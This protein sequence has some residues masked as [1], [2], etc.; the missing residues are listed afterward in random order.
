MFIFLSKKIAIPNNVKLRCASWNSEQGWIACGGQHGLLKVLRLESAAQTDGK[1]PRGI[2]AASNLTMNQSL[3]GH[4][5][6][7]V[8][9]T[10]NANFKKLTTSDEN[11]LIIVWVLHRGMW[12]E[13]MI[14][15]RNKS[16][17]RDM[18]WTTDG[19]KI[20][21][22]YEDGAVI[23][24][25]V[26]GNRLWGKEMKTQLAFVEWAPDGK[27]LLFVTKEGEV[28]VHDAMG[29]K[30]SNLTLY[31]VESRGGG[32][33]YKIIGVHWY[34]G[35]EGHISQEAPTLAIAFRDGKVQITRGR[36]DE[37]AV[38]I[39]TGME[40]TQ[41]R[42][43]NDGSVIA[44]A[45][46][47]VDNSASKGD[48]P[49]E[50]NVVQFYDPFGRH[51]RSLRVPG[52]RIEAL[53]WE[54]TGLRICLA[55]DSHIYF[56]NIRPAYKWGYYANTLVYTYNRA[57]QIENCVVF[58]DTKSD[59]R[60]TKY[61]RGLLAIKAAGDNCV[62]VTKIYNE[63]LGTG[64][65]NG[66]LIDDE[67][68]VFKE[69]QYQLILCDTIGSPIES[70]IIDFEP[71]FVAMTSRHIVAAS[72]DA[73][74][75]WQ[76][77][78]SSAKLTGLV[79]GHGSQSHDA[80]DVSTIS[81]LLQR[82]G[83]REKAF[84]ID[85]TQG[86]DV[87]HFR[88]VARQLEDPI[89]AICAS[90]SWIFA[91][92]ASGL[93][94]C[95][96]LPHI[97]LEM[98]YIVNCRPQFL[99]LNCNSTMLSVIDINGLLTIME[100]GAAGSLNTTQGKMLSFEKKDAW[101]V[102]WAEDNP[103]LFVM[104]EKARMYVYRS[105]E[106][107]EPVSSSGYLCYYK[108][109]QVKAA[110]LDEILANPEQ[111]DK[112]MVIEF[113]T[114]SLRDA[115]AL[116]D[117]VGLAEACEYIQDHP[118]PRLWS[119]LAEAALDQLDFGMAE[120]GFV[121]CG[122]YSGIQYVK[123]LQV[124]N[125]RVKQKAEVAAYF[126]NFD[127]AEA[128]Y[129]KIDRKDL[130]I[131]LRQ[132]LGD[133]FRVVQLVQ[134]GGGNDDLLTHAWNMIGEYFS[135]RHKWEK[136]IKYYAQ[137]KNTNALV[138]CYYALG[139]FNQL[140]ALVND[141]PESS[142]L[143][144]D[145]AVKFTRAGLCQSA[146]ET[147]VRMGD[148]KSAIDSCVLL[149]EWERAVGLAEQYNF[150]QIE[151]VLT[152]YASHLMMNGKTLQAIELYRRANKSTEAAKLLAKL[153][154][155]VA[156]NPLRAKKLH[157]LA[158][159][160]VERMRKKML[161]VSNLTS[162]KG[163]TAAQVTAQTLE[164]LVQHDAATGEDRSLD[165][166]W[167]GAEAYHL[168]LLAHRQLYG[169]RIERALRTCLKL[170]AYED[171]LE[172]REIYSLIALT[173]F[174]TK[175]YEQCSKAFVKLE[176]LPGLD[177]K[178]LQ[179][180]SELA[181]KIFTTTRTEH[182]DPTMRPQECPNCR[183]QVKEWDARCGNC[184]RP[185]PTCMMTGMSIQAQ[186]TKMCK[187]CRHVCIETEIRDQKNCP[188]CHTAFSF[189]PAATNKKAESAASGK[190]SDK[191]KDETEVEDDADEEEEAE[192]E[193]DEESD[194]EVEEDTGLTENQN[195]LL[196][197]VSLYSK[198]AVRA[199]DK[200][201]WIRKPAL[202]V[203]LYEAIV[204]KALDYD[205]APSSELVEN[206]RKY[207]NISQEGK[208]DL[209]FLR[210]EDLVNGLK[211]SSKTY[212]PVTCFQISEKGLEIIAK[213]SKT[214][215][216]AVN[217]MAYAPGTLHLLRVEWDGEEYWLV[218]DDSGYRRLSSVTETE[219][220]SYVSS[221]YIPQCL[222]FGGR[223]T[224]SNAHRAHECGVSDSSI[225]DQLDEIVTLNSVS[226][227]VAEYIPFGSNQ[228]VQL[229]CNLGSTERVQGGFFTAVV[230]DNA[231]GTQISVD[232]GLTSI[233]ILDYTMT[234]H[235]N[236]EADIHFPEA[237]GVVQVE[238]FG[239]AL[240]AAG[241]CLYGMQVEAIMDR[242][243][244]NV[245]LDH[246][247]RL[248]VD[249]HM[250]SSKIV[251]SV[252]SAYQR[253]LLGLIFSNQASS[254][255]KINLIIANEITPHLTAEEYMDKGEYENELKQVI[256]DTRAAFDISE[257]DTLVFGAH[258]LLIAGPNSRHH[259]P[260]LCSFLQYE[261]MNLF[262]QNFFARMFIIVDDMAQVRKL[263]ESAQKDPNRL[264]DIR[265]R[266]AVLSKEIIMMEETLSYLKESLD[267]AIVPAEPPEQA[268][269]SLYERLQL[270]ILSNQLKR[271]V[272]DLHKNMGGARHELV[273]LNEMASIV[274]SEKDFQQNEA[275]RMNTRTLCELQE[276]NERSASTLLIIKMM[277]SGLLAFS[278]LD[279]IT[280][281]WTVAD[282][283]WIKSFVE[284]M[285]YNNPGLWF[286]FSL[287]AWV[288]VGAG[289]VFLLRYLSFKSQG[290]VSIKVERKAPIQ[291][292]NLTSYLR[293]KLLDNETH[294]YEGG[295]RVA[296]VVWKEKDKKEWGGTVP[297]IEVRKT[298]SVRHTMDANLLLVA[299][300][301]PG[302]LEYDEEN[303]FMLRLAISYKKRQA[304]KAL[305]FNADELYTRLMQELDKARIFV[306]ADSSSSTQ[307]SNSA[308]A[309]LPSSKTATKKEETTSPPT[310]PAKQ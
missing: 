56:A 155:E 112:S 143:L 281:D 96:T 4:N 26:D 150:P 182:Q 14:N 47:Q 58:W 133:W 169:G 310:A 93:I 52:S 27:S 193:D 203:L 68:G 240:T 219:D 238:T 17:V 75:V 266:L 258:G 191:E 175:H 141:L 223:P 188:L 243:K 88:Y 307:A 229:N 43:N 176:T 199:S 254:R 51:L 111:P 64:E 299:A 190:K 253:S 16:V 184:S 147:Y 135:D 237:P 114:R 23:V 92:R 298:A 255:N 304:A 42:W 208:S 250:D 288:I 152:K 36:F 15:N 76:Y 286:F 148:V 167:R 161:D 13:E 113:Q 248:L 59:E 18:K 293:T 44:L 289:V 19:Q 125:D 231:S 22:A 90:D 65:V 80:M 271:R 210:E 31:A 234:N 9:A 37:N 39:D 270:G 5:G 57:D 154:K 134:S 115:K 151:N 85:E 170:S 34:D 10:W 305:A 107:E 109:L 290:V 122:D 172:E 265:S 185:F 214:D 242:I 275:I 236:F 24:G 263:I 139:D 274:S 126:Q 3:E 72:S 105:L 21:I 28:A 225:R 217:D 149:N 67:Q 2:A 98:K 83:G 201:E 106:P 267:E 163:T 165:N 95:F 261:S 195:R 252:L 215:K 123:R 46:T 295:I 280:G 272:K 119:L 38:L 118:H 144:K 221:A 306:D 101:D 296:K 194:E 278:I 84:Y 192:E 81:Q 142:P 291:L 171:I 232:P 268:G 132:R 137:A 200:E 273:V 287:F 244:D 218:D 283:D 197:L 79:S 32:N 29:N 180:M 66:Q 259:E 168:Y 202:L 140:E 189:K 145:M 120:R 277:L 117:N 186:G 160:E 183:C 205:Y 63:D 166:P 53:A 251:D 177:D 285:L 212:Q 97:S 50:F 206:K 20:C 211:L 256:G 249:V 226:L 276:I 61:I 301:S 127:E 6:A 284:V 262:T 178:E 297:S 257:H 11:G 153:A 222:R 71:L 157:V 246:L 62:L 89:C 99:A 69:I 103:E 94:H 48:A 241:S 124:L 138:Q 294:H 102:V 82:G 87:E 260:L 7:V 308:G 70:K 164:S 30:V 162:A 216:L 209:D 233:N 196:Y 41:V 220:V 78:N 136:A 110:L 173:A 60:Y 174:Y 181:L 130:A 309:A 245:S 108:D 204:S 230:D 247:S 158:A 33:D 146:V 49:K 45:G 54:G 73:I 224:L 228:V 264:R 100:V 77:K 128:L 129:R 303:A 35:I 279:R 302:Q 235:V 300:L 1:G 207:F 8:C 55:V 12:Y 104:M 121:K 40:L 156:K 269:R 74:Y 227:I 159:F 25:S 179:A 239:C 91:A 187:A 292:K 86:N 198:P 116:L 131:D 282:Q 213:I